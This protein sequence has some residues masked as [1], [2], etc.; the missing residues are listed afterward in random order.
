MLICWNGCHDLWYRMLSF[1][2]SK[3][4]LIQT[5]FNADISLYISIIRAMYV[6]S[7]YINPNWYV[8]VIT[9]PPIKRGASLINIYSKS[10]L[11]QGRLENFTVTI[12]DQKWPVTSAQLDGPAFHRCGQYPGDPPPGVTLEIACPPGGIPGRYVYVHT[13]HKD[14]ILT[15]CEA[16]VFACEYEYVLPIQIYLSYSLCMRNVGQLDNSPIWGF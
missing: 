15:I 3:I 13:P 5:S 8:D 1:E 9:Y 16:E 4:S 2:K 12:S 11:I 6:E 10:I 14:R 7:C